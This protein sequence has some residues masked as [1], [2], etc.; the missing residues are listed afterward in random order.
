[1]SLI[2]KDKAQADPNADE[3]DAEREKQLAEARAEKKRKHDERENAA[4]VR[5]AERTYH[6]AVA[7][8][9]DTRSNRV[10]QS[11]VEEEYGV[12]LGV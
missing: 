10:I 6:A 2:R 1:M 9:A 5:E 7:N 4:K 12:S 8:D 3:K 11:A